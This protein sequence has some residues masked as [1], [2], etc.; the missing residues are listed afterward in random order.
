LEIR[1]EVNEGQHSEIKDLS[2][3]VGG[4]RAV[5]SQAHD[6]QVLTEA[7]GNILMKATAYFALEVT[8]TEVIMKETRA[9]TTRESPD[10]Q[11]EAYYFSLML[12]RGASFSS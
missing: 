2:F 10:R 4:K 7:I 6:Y 3:P 5:M 11:L 12:A 9:V 8:T 1:T